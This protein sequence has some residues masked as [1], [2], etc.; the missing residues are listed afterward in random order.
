LLGSLHTL[1]I[2]FAWRVSDT[3]TFGYGV[4]ETANALGTLT[5]LWLLPRILARLNAGRTILLGFGVMGT[6][7]ALA[8]ASQS[9]PVV[10]ALAAGCGLG[11]MVFLVPSITLTQ[12][13]TPPAL[14]GRVF[15]VRLMLTFSAFSVSNAL[16]GGL[17]DS[18]GVSHLLLMLGGGMLLMA[19]AASLFASAREAV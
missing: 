2:G 14:R 6:A 18:V 3:G 8:G 4:V 7:V 15:A 17:A 10:A 11:N 16:A 12:R 13:Q 5:G 9:L 1:W 19:G